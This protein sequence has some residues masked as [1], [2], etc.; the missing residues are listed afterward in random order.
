[1]HQPK[2]PEERKGDIAAEEADAINNEFKRVGNKWLNCVMTRLTSISG[3]VMV[4]KEDGKLTDEQATSFYG[5]IR[6]IDTSATELLVNFD[7]GVLPP[8]DLRTSVINQIADLKYQIE[9]TI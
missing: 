6:A 2:T 7:S 5:Q 3:N 9:E 8:E 1:M 4:H